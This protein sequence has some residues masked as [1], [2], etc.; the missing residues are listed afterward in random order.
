MSKQLTLKELIE[1]GE[2]LDTRTGETTCVG[3]ETGYHM[4]WDWVET[5]TVERYRCKDCGMRMYETRTGI[6]YRL[7]SR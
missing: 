4:W 7:P 3:S 1:S 6:L 2:A 5:E